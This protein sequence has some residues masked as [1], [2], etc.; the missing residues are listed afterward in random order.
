LAQTK[1]IDSEWIIKDKA[2]RAFL[3]WQLR[4]LDEGGF[5]EDF[6]FCIK[7]QCR[8]GQTARLHVPHRKFG[9]TSAEWLAKVWDNEADAIYD[10]E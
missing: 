1:Y 6:Y 5:T 3:R 2:R 4:M 10:D 8:H 7:C 9:I